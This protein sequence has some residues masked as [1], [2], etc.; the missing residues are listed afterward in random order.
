MFPL[1]NNSSIFQ[2]KRDPYRYRFPI[3]MRFVDPNIDH[4]MYVKS[5][6]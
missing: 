6:F 5:F 2:A 1:L 4:L 3:E